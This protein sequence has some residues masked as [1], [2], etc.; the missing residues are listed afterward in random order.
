VK[1][2]L[3]L[4]LGV[5][6]LLSLIEYVLQSRQIEEQKNEISGLKTD[7]WVQQ[8]TSQILTE[9]ATRYYDSV[10]ENIELRRKL[11]LESET[12]RR[13]ITSEQ[14][15]LLAQ[16]LSNLRKS[17]III[18]WWPVYPIP[19]HAAG[20]DERTLLTPH[21]LH[22]EI[23]YTTIEGKGFAISDSEI[24]SRRLY[25]VLSRCG[26]DVSVAFD[27]PSDSSSKGVLLT[28][29]D[30]DAQVI[31]EVLRNSLHASGVR[32]VTIQPV[33]VLAKG[34]SL[35]IDVGE[36]IGDMPTH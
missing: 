1:L 23:L 8:Q 25:T 27:L 35:K 31:A 32:G 33:Q 13:T 14:E 11:N 30:K 12:V 16:Q 26:C 28:P 19:A 29:G 17:R 4:I 7:L 24:F 5:T 36:N 9:F 18:H 20:V 22:G 2:I 3:W 10:D 34:V 21:D 15:R 6:I